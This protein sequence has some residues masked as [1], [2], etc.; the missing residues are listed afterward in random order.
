VITSV[1]GEPIALLV[2]KVV[3][4]HQTVIKSLGT[5]C[6]NVRE[7]SGVTI[8]GEVTVGH[9]LDVPQLAKLE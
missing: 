1:Y 5:A 4:E 8:P 7:M 2:D 6:R 9:I 3:G